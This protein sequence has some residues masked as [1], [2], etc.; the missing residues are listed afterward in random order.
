LLVVAVLG[1]L[2]LLAP[3]VHAGAC[4]RYGIAAELRTLPAETIPPDGGV[5][6]GYGQPTEDQPAVEQADPSAHPEWRFRVKTS[7]GKKVRPTLVT[8]APGLSVYRTKTRGKVVLTDGKGKK[9]GAFTISRKKAAFAATAPVLKKVEIMRYSSSRGGTSV[10][11]DATFDGKPP[12]GA[13]AVVVYD[14]ASGNAM[15]WALTGD[16][17]SSAL[18][19]YSSPGRCSSIP[20]G[21]EQ[22]SAGQK[23]EVAWVDHFGRISPHSNV[24]TAAD[25]SS[26]ATV[27]P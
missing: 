5:L 16:N 8:I 20:P 21:T 1:L 12:A 26:S 22:P 27:G 7:K 14:S 4:A 25:A 3:D 11:A 15:S 10:G 2:G 19:I 9:L 24:V 23:L 13:Y 17:S 18:G 6:V